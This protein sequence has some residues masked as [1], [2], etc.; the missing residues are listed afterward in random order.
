VKKASTLFGSQIVIAQ[1]E[2]LQFALAGETLRQERLPT[3]IVASFPSARDTMWS[4]TQNWPTYCCRIDT[5]EP[6]ASFHNLFSPPLRF[7][8]RPFVTADDPLYNIS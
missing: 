7:L 2:C 8:F 3:L 1:K 5:I 4:L 6:S